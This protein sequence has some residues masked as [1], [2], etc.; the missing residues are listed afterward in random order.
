MLAK[1]G[2]IKYSPDFCQLTLPASRLRLAN[3]RTKGKQQQNC[4]KIHVPARKFI[5][6]LFHLFVSHFVQ[7][8]WWRGR[9]RVRGASHSRHQIS[10]ES[11]EEKL[12][13]CCIS[14][15]D[16]ENLTSPV[17]CFSQCYFRLSRFC[18]DNDKN[19]FDYF[20]ACLTWLAC[21]HLE[22]RLKTVF[23]FCIFFLSSSFECISFHSKISF[24]SCWNFFFRTK[25]LTLGASS[26]LNNHL[27]AFGR[28][29]LW[30]IY[31]HKPSSNLCT[32]WVEMRQNEE[33]KKKAS[34]CF[35]AAFVCSL[36]NSSPLAQLV[37]VLFNW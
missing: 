25:C 16:E 5:D 23:E 10:S 18:F 12:N 8:C 3:G 22:G 1:Y 11:G 35:D 13:W 14:M 2:K 4:D 15:G 30:K 31:S 28:I 27:R 24:G 9:L 36:S 17:L 33:T 6:I 21:V 34:I 37:R 32:A 20:V 26:C 7:R 29:V 19:S